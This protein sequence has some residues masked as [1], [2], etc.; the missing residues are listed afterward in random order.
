MASRKRKAKDALDS[1]TALREYTNAARIATGD[2]FKYLGL[3]AANLRRALSPYG[4]VKAWIVAGH[5]LL[6]GLA[7]KKASGHAVATY[8]A[9][10]KHFEQEIALAQVNAAKR[11]RGARARGFAFGT[12]ASAQTASGSERTGGGA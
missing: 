2:E 7:C 5:L 6:A 12:G 11:S 4:R 9:F 1:V 3:A 8:M 10:L